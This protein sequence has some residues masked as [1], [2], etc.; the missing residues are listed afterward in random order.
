M[1]YYLLPPSSIKFPFRIFYF[2]FF[3][4]VNQK[5][6]YCVSS[7]SVQACALKGFFIILL[8]YTVL[9]VTSPRN[10]YVEEKDGE[11]EWQGHAVEAD[12]DHPLVLLLGFVIEE[13]SVD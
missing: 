11:R 6:S 1:E 5:I 13:Y 9:F 3:D 8:F 7:E 10:D 2:Q 12:A 4:V